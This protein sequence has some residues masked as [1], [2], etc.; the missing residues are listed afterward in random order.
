MMILTQCF[1]TKVHGTLLQYYHTHF[2]TNSDSKTKNFKKKNAIEIRWDEKD[3]SGNAALR[4]IYTFRLLVLIEP[5][6]VI[7]TKMQRNAE[8]ACVNGICQR[9]LRK[10][11]INNSIQAKPEQKEARQDI[12]G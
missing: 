3:G 4:R 12:A 7:T 10:P 9:G 6:K 11:E 2:W 1:S 8:N 5:T